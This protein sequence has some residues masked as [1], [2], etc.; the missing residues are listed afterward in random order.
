MVL[1]LEQAD[2]SSS[3]DTYVSVAPILAAVGRLYGT[4]NA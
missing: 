1:I 3:N 4:S 2:T